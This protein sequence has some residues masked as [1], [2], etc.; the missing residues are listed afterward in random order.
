MNPRMLAL[1]A[2]FAL[3]GPHALATA[4]P[5]PPA[6]PSPPAVPGAPSIAMPPAPPVPPAPPAP[7]AVP[8]AAHAACAGQPDGTRLTHVLDQGATMTG[9]CERAGGK[10]TFRLREFRHDA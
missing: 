10:P 1:T 6:P 5:V 9:V 2:T 4:P 3:L 7:P 8:A